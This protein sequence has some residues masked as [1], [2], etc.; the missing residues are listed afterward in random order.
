MSSCTAALH[1]AFVLAGVGPGDEVVCPSLTYVAGHQ[2]VTATGADVVFCDVE[3]ETLGVSPDSLR[4]VVGERTRAILVLHYAGIPAAGLDA[5][6]ELADEHGLRVVEDAAHAFGSTHGGRPIGSFG[7]LTCFSFGPV[8]II[9][10][11][12]GGAIVTGNEDDVRL[13]HELRLVGRDEGHRDPLRGPAHLGLRRRP[14]GLPL[15][16][17]L[18]PGC[19]RPLAARARRRLHPQPAG[20]LPRRSTS[21]WRGST[22]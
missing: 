5:V 12:E 19:D 4:R 18:D 16:P 8:K 6:Y 20:L 17:R 13:L 15:P 11:L 2:A 14:A 7:D 9:T 22:A 21:A 1:A 3:E 10:S